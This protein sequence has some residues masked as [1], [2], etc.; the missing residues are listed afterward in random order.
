MCRDG[1]AANQDATFAMSPDD[2][3]IA[4]WAPPIAFDRK[5]CVT[6]QQLDFAAVDDACMHN[7]NAVLR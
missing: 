3:D 1:K 5:F 7:G 4:D 2:R 6:P